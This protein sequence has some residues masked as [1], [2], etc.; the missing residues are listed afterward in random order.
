MKK[1]AVPGH[2]LVTSAGS[3][4]GALDGDPSL[5]KR[6]ESCGHYLVECYHVSLELSI[7]RLETQLA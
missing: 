1:L 2:S 6:E 7:F 4:L 3:A 5:Q